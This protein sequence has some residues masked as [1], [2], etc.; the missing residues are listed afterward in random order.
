LP[1]ICYWNG[2]LGMPLMD[3]VDVKRRS[4]VCC[5]KNGGCRSNL[6]LNLVEDS[7]LWEIWK[8]HSHIETP[9]KI[10]KYRTV[11]DQNWSLPS[12]KLT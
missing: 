1:Q 3:D 5:W 7:V 11:I 10:Q 6:G 9:E 4:A 2:I 12:G 8:K